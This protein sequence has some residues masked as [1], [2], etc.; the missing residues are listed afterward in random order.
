[1]SFNSLVMHAHWKNLAEIPRGVST[2]SSSS[3]PAGWVPSSPADRL[4][5]PVSRQ[6]RSKKFGVGSPEKVSGGVLDLADADLEPCPCPCAGM[7]LVVG[8]S[9]SI[10]KQVFDQLEWKFSL[11]RADINGEEWMGDG[12]TQQFLVYRNR[13]LKAHVP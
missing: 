6:L 7:E 9:S 12:N 5:S 2:S 11:M 4:E 3:K 10:R 1:M 8:S 13:V